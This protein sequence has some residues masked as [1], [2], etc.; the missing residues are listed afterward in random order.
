MRLLRSELT[1]PGGEG[2]RH[3]SDSISDRRLVTD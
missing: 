1:S 3:P 2:T